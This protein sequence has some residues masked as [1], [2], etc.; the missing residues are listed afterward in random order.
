MTAPWRGS[1]HCDDWLAADAHDWLAADAM[2][3]DWRM[4]R[5]SHVASA[6]PTSLPDPVD[7]KV[8]DQFCAAYGLSRESLIDRMGGSP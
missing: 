5:A 8:L 4:R 2:T 3:S 1:G 6:A 7:T